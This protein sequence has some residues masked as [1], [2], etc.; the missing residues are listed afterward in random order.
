MVLA[1]PAGLVWCTHTE[2]LHH[3]GP[4]ELVQLVDD[5]A[6]LG[7]D[8]LGDLEIVD[9]LLDHLPAGHLDADLLGAESHRLE[10][11]NDRS[12]QFGLGGH[13]SHEERERARL[14]QGGWRE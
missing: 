6:G 11:G 5:D 13:L 8:L 2:L 14:N 4:L 3:V 1:S 12:Q 10:E 7:E 9:D